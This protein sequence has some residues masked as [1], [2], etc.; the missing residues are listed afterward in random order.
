MLR[1][2]FAVR[3]IINWHYFSLDVDPRSPMITCAHLTFV[4]ERMYVQSY[5]LHRSTP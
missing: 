3:S 2:L 1:S 5:Q 4:Q